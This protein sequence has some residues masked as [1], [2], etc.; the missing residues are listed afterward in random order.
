LDKL[1]SLSNEIDFNL[2]RSLPEIQLDKIYK[3][4]TSPNKYYIDPG[5]ELTFSSFN[6]LLLVNKKILEDLQIPKFEFVKYYLSLIKFDINIESYS[7]LSTLGESFFGAPIPLNIENTFVKDYGDY[8][9]LIFSIKVLLRNIFIDEKHMVSLE[10]YF[11]NNIDFIT[12]YYTYTINIFDKK[13][14]I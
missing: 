4:Y 14:V 10:L 2:L 5:Q 3:K 8:L 7:Q 6:G 1:V 11:D 13:G 9:G 12:L